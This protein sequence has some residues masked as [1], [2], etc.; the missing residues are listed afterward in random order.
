MNI[1]PKLRNRSARLRSTDTSL[2]VILEF[3]G[4]V[5]LSVLSYWN[6]ADVLTQCIP[7][8]TDPVEFFI[9]RFNDSID[10]EDSSLI[11]FLEDV[12]LLKEENITLIEV[13]D[14]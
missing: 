10:Y 14:D 6:D 11:E 7:G 9:G 8:D 3:R 5:D 13:A 12:G 1:L 4:T 2:E